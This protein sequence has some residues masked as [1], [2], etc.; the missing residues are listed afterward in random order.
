MELENSL[1][2]SQEPATS[3]YAE[4][5]ASNPQLPI[6]FP[7]DSFYYYPLPACF[8]IVVSSL[9]GFRPKMLYI[10]RVS[11]ASYIPHPCPSP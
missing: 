9:P 3:P 2:C 4:P 7:G 1:S 11:H 8:F 10:F 6:T 5:D